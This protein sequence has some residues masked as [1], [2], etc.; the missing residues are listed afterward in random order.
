MAHG[1]CGRGN[2]F[3]RGANRPR[4]DRLADPGRAVHVLVAVAAAVTEEVPVDVVVVARA[5]AADG[6]VAFPG[7]GVAP[8]RAVRADRRGC[9]QVPLAGVVLLEGLVGEDA[10]G[11]D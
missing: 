7:N 6:A 8:H 3:F 9:L 5:D 1:S 2:S 11:T 10:R 4:N